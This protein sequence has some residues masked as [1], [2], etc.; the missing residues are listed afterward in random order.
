LHSSQAILEA[1][2]KKKKTNA[3]QKKY[4]KK[5]KNFTWKSKVKNSSS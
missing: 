5:E 2:K 3:H 1:K 4:P